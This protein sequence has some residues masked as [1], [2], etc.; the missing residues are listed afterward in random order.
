[1]AAGLF[2]LGFMFIRKKEYFAPPTGSPERKKIEKIIIGPILF[3]VFGMVVIVLG[4]K[5]VNLFERQPSA[6][7][8]KESDQKLV[9]KPDKSLVNLR[10]TDTSNWQTY[11]S[12]IC[13][14]EIKFP[15]DL[16]DKVPVSDVFILRFDKNSY[17][18]IQ[19]LS[20]LP[21]TKESYRPYGA[22]YIFYEVKI[23]D[24]KEADQYYTKKPTGQGIPNLPFTNYVI[25]L[26]DGGWLQISYFSAPETKK[27]FEKVLSTFKFLD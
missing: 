15:A 1:M 26:K 18:Q 8:I 16:K 11:Q 17:M 22:E 12:K 3:L 7:Q 5:F 2:W 27:I 21:P 14:Y 10:Q 23:I 13:K 19:C 24:G 20:G 9:E 6:S 25:P 4:L